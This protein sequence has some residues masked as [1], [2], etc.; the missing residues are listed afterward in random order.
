MSNPLK[1]T[2]VYL[3]LAD[4]EFENENQQAS[5]PAPA[6]APVVHAAPAPAP[7]TGA[8]VTPLR[9][10]HVQPSTPQAEMNEI[11]TVHPR[12]YRDAQVIAESFREGVPVIIKLSQMSDADARR[13]IDFA[14]G[15][16][17][18]LPGKIERVTSKVVLLSPAHVVVSGESGDAEGDDEASFFTHA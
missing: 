16:S 17:Q 8:A 3:G 15:L 9:R 14:S 10:H 12:Q 7:K 18:G 5:T 4:E 2:M 11:L 1:K 13:L 6:S